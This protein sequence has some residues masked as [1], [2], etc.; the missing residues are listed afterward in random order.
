MIVRILEGTVVAGAEADFA[1]VARSSLPR[2]REAPGVRFIH[3]ARRMTAQGVMEFAWVSVWDD[4]AALSAF[5]QESGDPPAF[6]RANR[7]LIAT[8]R[9]RHLETFDGPDV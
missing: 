9:L 5:D 3:L 2:F 8:W 1:E 4:A 7:S 6:V